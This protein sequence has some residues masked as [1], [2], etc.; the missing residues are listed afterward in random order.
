MA[1]HAARG[2]LHDRRL[3]LSVP[4]VVSFALVLVGASVAV[5]MIVGPGGTGPIGQASPSAVAS[6][7]GSP[8]AAETAEPTAT[9]RPTP[10]PTP[11]SVPTPGP[12]EW[13]GLAWSEPVTPS[14]VVH[15]NDLVPWRDGYVAVGVVP[16]QGSASF[17][18]PDGLHWTVEQRDFPGTPR[19]LV[20]L[21]DELLAFM[22]IVA[23][24]SPPGTIVGAPPTSLI[25]RSTDGVTWALVDSMTW[26]GAWDEAVAQS[27]SS[28]PDGWDQTQHDLPLGVV[29][30]ASGPAIER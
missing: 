13:T 1:T 30:V 3:A 28:Y 18:S 22:P 29:D 15:L 10:R 19:H 26:M 25:W 4:I 21:G 27:V 2:P 9:P 6:L 11:T 12:A 24:T 17:T 23:R 20:G 14:F 16:E 7:A 8:T 5:W